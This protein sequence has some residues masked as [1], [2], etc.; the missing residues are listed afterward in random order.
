ML[1]NTY[2]Y[3]VF[4]GNAAEAIVF[5]TTVFD[6][7]NLDITYFRD[8][9]EGPDFVVP[10]EA[11]DLVMNASIELPNGDIFMFSDNMPGMPFTVG[12]Q[13]TVALI[14]DD[15]KD[16]E[17]IFNLLSEDGEIHMELQETDWSPLYGNVTDRYGNLWQV[18][19][20]M[21]SQ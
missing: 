15:V 9:P 4:D 7:K 21:K 6:A 1:V 14:F 5:Y 10:E 8:L 17:R 13:I 12:D 18:S 16:T 20:E 11:K 3:F 19:T 2:P